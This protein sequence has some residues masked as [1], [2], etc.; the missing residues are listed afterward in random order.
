MTFTQMGDRY[1]ATI[2]V[3]LCLSAFCTTNMLMPVR[4]Y[5]DV[6]AT[7]VSVIP[8]DLT[9]CPAVTVSDIHPYSYQGGL[10]AFEMTVS[11]PRYVAMQASVGDS[12]IPFQ[13]LTR[14]SNPNGSIRIHVDLY[15][16]PL[17]GTV[18]VQVEFLASVNGRTCFLNVQSSFIGDS[19]PA[20]ANQQNHTTSSSFGS[21]DTATKPSGTG[22]GSHVVTGTQSGTGVTI[23]GT[24][25][26]GTPVIASSSV[27][28]LC[29]VGGAN[30]LW[31]LLVALF[32]IF[33]LILT[34]QKPTES[35]VHLR[36]WNM[37]LILAV[38]L[39]LM[40]FWYVSASCRTGVWV[41]FVVAG[42]A[43][44]SLFLLA[45]RNDS[46]EMLLLQESK[47]GREKK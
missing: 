32:A 46:P 29:S 26:H 8:P 19:E 45:L 3:T 14:N 44:I 5:A 35:D 4:A 20:N 12:V 23:V 7:P 40:V 34:F 10:D 33:A 41:P 21:G 36:E 16:M 13:F 37:A 43:G 39:G 1:L 30:V 17:N 25:T 47:K 18:P 15:R 42:I 9:A 27:G 11:D 24:T 22:Q 38:F 31:Y 28:K 2:A 6:V